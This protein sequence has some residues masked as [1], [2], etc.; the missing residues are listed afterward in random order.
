MDVIFYER[1]LRRELWGFAT[2]IFFISLFISMITAGLVYAPIQWL[3]ARPLQRLMLSMTCFQ[4]TPED[5]R[6]VISP[7]T[8]KDKTGISE[9][10][11]GSMRQ[12]L[13][14]ALLQ[15]ERLAGV[16]T[17][18]TKIS[19]DL[20]N[21]LATAMLESER[22][23]VLTDPEVERLTAGMVRAVDRAVSLSASTLRFSKE[24]LPHVSKQP[25][26]TVALLEDLKTHIKP[27]L[28]TAAIKIARNLDAPF[29]GGIDLLRW[30]FENLLCNA[31]EAGAVSIEL[32]ALEDG[33]YQ[34]IRV[35]DNGSG[36]MPKAR[37]NLFAPFS[38]SA[39]AGGCGLGLPIVRE[40][41]RAQCGD[42]TLLSTGPQGACFVV[43]LPL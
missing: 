4:N 33:G 14:T 12:E 20:K 15:K 28:K 41:L 32:I 18:V 25:L 5:S 17:T 43:R 21:I 2:R 26:R 8:R 16:G 3:A 11:L 39:R 29:A 19:N 40:L 7:S 30:A 34:T 13:H 37:D 42:V 36:L 23:A 6:N 22:L 9:Q 1:Q 24:G 27:A 38:G 35:T 31:G 10:A